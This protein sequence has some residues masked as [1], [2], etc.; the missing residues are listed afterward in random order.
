MAGRLSRDVSHDGAYFVDGRLRI[1]PVVHE[2]FG[3][4]ERAA[5]SMAAMIASGAE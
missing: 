4:P 5:L 2:S 1:D 3:A